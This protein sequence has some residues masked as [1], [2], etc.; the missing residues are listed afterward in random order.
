MLR[1]THI[2]FSHKVLLS[3]IL[4]NQTEL[5]IYE[6]ITVEYYECV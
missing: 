6:A 1:Y 2:A 3:N 4:R 5:I